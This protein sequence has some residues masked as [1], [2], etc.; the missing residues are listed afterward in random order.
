MTDTL[1]AIRILL[2]IVFATS[3]LIIYLLIYNIL[4]EKGFKLSDF[5]TNI[6]NL[7]DFSDIIDKTE[8][9]KQ[10]R[11]YKILLRSFLFSLFL[12]IGTILTFL[13][14]L[15][16]IDCRHYHSYLKSETTGK[17][18][19]KFI[20]TKNH[21]QTTLTIELNGETFDDTDL[22][23]TYFNFYDSIQIGDVLKKMRGDSI[24]YIMRNGQ[25]IK[26]LKSRKDY[27]KN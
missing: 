18:M 9:R 16:N 12:F 22:T 23:S 6:N 21:N 1:D 7:L 20:N 14:D 24:L 19:N 13:I 5:R 10:K 25:E 27:C 2:L 8:D 4:T 3:G 15:K 17:V 11:Y 26:I